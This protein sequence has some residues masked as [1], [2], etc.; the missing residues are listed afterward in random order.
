[1]PNNRQWA[2]FVWLLV[3]GAFVLA[4]RD[5]R[6]MVTDLVRQFCALKIMVP[7]LLFT[8]Y[9]AGVIAAGTALGGWTPE[10]TT[11]T[12]MWFGGALALLFRA[13]DITKER[14]FIR[15]SLVEPMRAAALL[16]F[17]IGLFPL[18]LWAELLLLPIVALAVALSV[19]ASGQKEHAAAKRLADSVLTAGGLALIG[20]AIYR[21]IEA[22]G[23]VGSTDTVRALLLPMWAIAA[24]V[25]VVYLFGVV[26][27]YEQVALRIGHAGSPPRRTRQALAGVASVLKLR[28]REI[29]TFDTFWA[30]RVSEAGSFEAA[31]AVASRYRRSLREKEEAV[32]RSE[33][34]LREYAGVQ[35]TDEEGRQ[36]DQREFD[37]TRGALQWLATVQMGC[38]HNGARYKPEALDLADP[39]RQGLLADHGIR[40]VVREDGQAWYAWR[41]TPSDW[42]LGIG[43]AAP[44]PD[45][46]LGDGPQSP[47]GF[48][49]LDPWWGSGPFGPD[50]A[51]W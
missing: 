48:P 23:T 16:V 47:N 8:G 41:R 42:R 10:R 20:W 43:A 31:R 29:A 39:P 12:V 50:A 40:M 33:E 35:G 36:L 24:V 26:M 15:H 2:A 49:G 9:C 28:V 17:F 7:V 46:W 21:A 38:Y 14:Q 11:D 45:Q 13:T 1:M 18:P 32:R 19:V 27:Y 30:A 3:L 44:P 22:W 37:V 4:R 51:N 25:P 6:H 34:R 5:F